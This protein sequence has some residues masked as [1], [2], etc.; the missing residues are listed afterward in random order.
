MRITSEITTTPI[1]INVKV[2]PDMFDSRNVHFYDSELA[3]KLL[4]SQTRYGPI[5]FYKGDNVIGISLHYYGE[6]TQY[7][8][9][10]LNNFIHRSSIIYDIGANIGFHS[11][12]LAEQSKH[13]YAFEPNNKNYKLLKL[14]TGHINNIST[15]NVGC[16]DKN[17][18]AFIQ[19]FEPGDNFNNGELMLADS[20]QPCDIVKLDDFAKENNIPDPQ[21]IKIDVEGHEYEVLLGMDTMIR[22]NLPVIFY[23]HQ[24]GKLPEIHDYLTGLGYTIYWF[25]SPNYNPNNYKNNK[26]QIFHPNSAVINA[27]A[28]PFHIDIK[29]NLPKKLSRT[30]TYNDMVE[31]YMKEHAKN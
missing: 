2:H 14:N 22:N 10:L 11:L 6:Y 20:G 17:G 29:T 5:N 8:I 4:Y 28:I 24:T 9:N 7:E 19:D 3:D 30:E 15:Y 12:G 18:T 1:D 16:S 13:L 27:L 26:T 23:E 25:A 31:R 21:V